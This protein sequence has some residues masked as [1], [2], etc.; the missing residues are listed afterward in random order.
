MLDFATLKLTWRPNQY[1]VAPRGL[2]P[3]AQ[4]HRESPVFPLPAAALMERFKA[5]ALAQP[6]VTLL[7]EDKVAHKLE[8]VQRSAFFRF[9]DYISV[10]VVPDG[11]G[12]ST[13]AVYSRARYGI[14]DFGVNKA[15]IDH[16]LAA[17]FGG[18]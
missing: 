11:D 15:R 18:A 10:E 4:P 13:I 7:A 5:H 2:T 16:W 14:R 9:P 3:G 6:R 8:L 17:V 1:L 12:R